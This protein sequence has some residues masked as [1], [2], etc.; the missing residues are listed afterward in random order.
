MTSNDIEKEGII[1]ALANNHVRY[2]P[3]IKIVFTKLININIH[4][5]PFI[6]N[7]HNTEKNCHMK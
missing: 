4:P 1:G 6:F 3:Y 5:F 2:L 7:Q